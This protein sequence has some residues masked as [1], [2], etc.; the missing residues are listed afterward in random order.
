MGC[1]GLRCLYNPQNRSKMAYFIALCGQALRLVPRSGQ[2]EVKEETAAAINGHS[3]TMGRS[4][5]HLDCL[6]GSYCFEVSHIIIE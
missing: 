2:V 6:Y 3:T 1:N 4:A 5:Q